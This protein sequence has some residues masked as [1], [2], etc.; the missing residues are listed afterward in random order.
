[1]V[2]TERIVT[3]ETPTGTQINQLWAAQPLD[4]GNVL[5]YANPSQEQWELNPD[6]GV[7]TYL[8]DGRGPQT[9]SM[10][11]DGTQDG[12]R[13]YAAFPKSGQTI[14]PNVGRRRGN[15]R[16]VHSNLATNGA[17][18]GRRNIRGGDTDDIINS[19]AMAGI[20]GG[21]A[22]LWTT[23]NLYRIDRDSTSGDLQ[24]TLIGPHGLTDIGAAAYF[25]DRFIVFASGE[26]R[27]FNV[28][29]QT[30]E[31]YGP[32]PADL[33]N[34]FVRN[35]VLMGLSERRLITFQESAVSEA[36]GQRARREEVQVIVRDRRTLRPLP[37][38]FID[39]SA[40]RRVVVNFGW[41]TV[42]TGRIEFRANAMHES[43]AQA[44]VDG[45]G[46][47][48]VR[49]EFLD[50]EGERREQ[51]YLGLVRHA[52]LQKTSRDH[53]LFSVGDRRNVIIVLGGEGQGTGDE[54]CRRVYRVTDRHDIATLGIHEE[55]FD[56]R[57]ADTTAAMQ[58][59]GAARLREWQ[60]QDVESRTDHSEQGT[61]IILHVGLADIWDYAARRIVDT[62]GASNVEVGGATAGAYIRNLLFREFDVGGEL[63]YR[64]VE[65]PWMV[66]A[67]SNNVGLAVEHPIRWESCMDVITLV[68]RA[69]D[70]G[71]RY[72]LRDPGVLEYAVIDGRNRLSGEERLVV[73]DTF[74][75]PDLDLRPGDRFYR[76]VWLPNTS[77]PFIGGEGAPRAQVCTELEIEVRPQLATR[78]R[79]LT[80]NP[81][82]T[83]Q[84][85]IDILQK[86]T[87]L[88]RSD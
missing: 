2:W 26:L 78:V 10:T 24:A 74:A 49:R 61:D 80:G 11:W 52:R 72:R 54:A 64:S 87:A 37:H 75:R 12:R 68:C 19:R 21:L 79:P 71:L 60:N 48:E 20:I 82:I 65:P 40:Y 29:D 14:D 25:G 45:T 35:G 57:K 6:T 5:L 31:Y 86:Q 15:G 30:S 73:S 27:T 18:A 50:T 4:N 56:Q 13:V 63:D 28:A 36:V 8:R 38:G 44:L 1:M 58:T 85:L 22:Y 32:A 66:T 76:E 47:I 42:G 53:D 33:R 43:I 41:Q 67:E 83:T 62:S 77:R 81:P 3:G 34:L 16:Q 23:V 17:D 46:M 55:F 70:V 7:A 88:A 69:S 59:A 84:G 39:Q 51:Q 9:A